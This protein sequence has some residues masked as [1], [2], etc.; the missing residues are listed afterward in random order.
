MVLAC[1]EPDG[2]IIVD[3]YIAN[4]DN[5]PSGLQTRIR[6]TGHPYRSRS[7]Y[8]VLIIILCAPCAPDDVEGMLAL[9]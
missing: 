3:P 5:I 2:D 1:E 8:R 9:H 7:A 6:T 4:T